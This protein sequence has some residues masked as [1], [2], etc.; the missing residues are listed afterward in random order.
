MAT[1][2]QVLHWCA[3]GYGPATFFLASVVSVA[4]LGAIDTEEDLRVG[5][6]PQ[7]LLPYRTLFAFLCAALGSILVLSCSLF[8]P[9]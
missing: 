1:S 2:V 5:I 4:L 8:P 9:I 6:V 7:G 3:A